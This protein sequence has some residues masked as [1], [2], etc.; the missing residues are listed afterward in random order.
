MDTD[1]SNDRDYLD[2]EKERAIIKYVIN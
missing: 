2:A 1:N